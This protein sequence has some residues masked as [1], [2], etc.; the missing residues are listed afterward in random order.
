ME[1]LY[2]A[3]LFIQISFSLNVQAIQIVLNTVTKHPKVS[4]VSPLFLHLPNQVFINLAPE[5]FLS[6]GG[7]MSRVQFLPIIETAGKV[8]SGEEVE[9]VLVQLL[10]PGVHAELQQAER[11]GE[12]LW[13]PVLVNT[14]AFLFQVSK[15]KPYELVRSWLVL[16][17]FLPLPP[18]LLNH[19]SNKA[20]PGLVLVELY[21]L[22]VVNRC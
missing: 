3:V 18:V 1:T 12:V 10:H 21:K 5:L 6:A 4:V 7:S 17:S 2:I 22:L 13:A 16:A 15:N 14:F 9:G 20:C 11:T 19:A 8:C